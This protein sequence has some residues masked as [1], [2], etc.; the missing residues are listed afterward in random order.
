MLQIQARTG[1]LDP[2]ASCIERVLHGQQYNCG[3]MQDSLV[4]H[5]NINMIVIDDL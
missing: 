2:L 1:P 5:N 4:P 3:T